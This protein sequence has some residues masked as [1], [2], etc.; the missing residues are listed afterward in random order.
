MKNITE[1]NKLIAEFLNFKSTNKCV[2]S[3]TGRYYDFY[4]NPKFSC[5]KEQEIQIESENGFGLVEQD[6]LF[7]EDLKFHSD[8]NWLMEVVEK[9]LIG[10]AEHSQDEAK[11]AISEIYE[12][13]CSINISAVYNAC[14]SF[15]EWYNEQK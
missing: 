10:E 5:I 14:I 13:L 9:C 8:W 11:K 3:E 12:S 6:F 15:I 2:R 1:N 4:A 7:V